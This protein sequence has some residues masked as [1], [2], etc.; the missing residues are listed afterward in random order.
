MQTQYT[1]AYLQGL[2]TGGVDFSADTFKLAL[3][4]SAA[5]LDADTSA[6]T[7]TGEVTGTGYTAGGATL[8]AA[9]TYPKIADGKY[10]LHFDDA[11][12]ASSTITARAAL[13]YDVTASN[14]ACLIIDFGQDVASSGQPFT[15]KFSA[16][17][18]PALEIG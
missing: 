17:T 15:L 10:A 2:G 1:T 16:M 6:Y 9:S 14:L 7:A 5:T 18:R 12:W 3:Y 11:T 13:I 8:S 4:T